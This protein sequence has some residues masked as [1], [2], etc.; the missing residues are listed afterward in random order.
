MLNY[1][2]EA[3]LLVEVAIHTHRVTTVQQDLNNKA[4]REALNLLTHSD[5]QCLP[6]DLALQSQV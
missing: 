2:S 6:Q 1:S 5:G 3:V 4:L